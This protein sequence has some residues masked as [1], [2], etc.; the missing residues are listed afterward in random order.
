MQNRNTFTD[1]ENKLAVTKREEGWQV[2]DMGL[3]DVN[4]FV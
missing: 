1:I 2:R 3:R 4:Y